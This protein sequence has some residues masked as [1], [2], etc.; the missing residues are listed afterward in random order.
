MVQGSH[1][2]FH[3][4]SFL[5]SIRCLHRPKCPLEYPA[6][7]TAST[8]SFAHSLRSM[9]NPCISMLS[10]GV[11]QSPQV[12]SV[13]GHRKPYQHTMAQTLGSVVFLGDSEI[14]DGDDDL[15]KLSSGFI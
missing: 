7:S 3:L 4:R 15:P 12:P 8:I 6:V 2:L 9:G 13:V 10:A 14:S 11:G 5:P 1:I